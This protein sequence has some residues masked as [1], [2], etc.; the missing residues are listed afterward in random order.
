[1]PEVVI[2]CL[3]SI[4][5]LAVGTVLVSTTRAGEAWG[6]FSR[7]AS[8]FFTGLQFFVAITQAVL[9]I[10]QLRLIR[11]SLEDAK[12]VSAAAT[13][14]ARVAEDTLTKIERPYVFVYNASSLKID[15]GS[16]KGDWIDIKR[17]I[18]GRKV[19]IRYRGTFSSGHVTRAC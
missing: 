10:Y 15:N 3:L 6:W 12:V 19:I 11:V 17:Q 1:M 13:R 8:G 5:A 16:M 18:L 4:A 7:D 9:I 14:Q 2:G